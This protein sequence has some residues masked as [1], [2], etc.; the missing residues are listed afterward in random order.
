MTQKPNNRVNVL[1]P[2]T[3]TLWHI[4][5]ILYMSITHQQIEQDGCPTL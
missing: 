1:L 4:I 3:L 2:Q 5:P